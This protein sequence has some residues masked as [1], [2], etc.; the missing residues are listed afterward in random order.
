[1]SEFEISQFMK[2]LSGFMVVSFVL[3]IVI[4]VMQFFIG[5]FTVVIFGYGVG[6]L[7]LMVYNLIGCIKYYKNINVIKNFSTKSE[8]AGCVA[9]F[10]KSIPMC[11]IF[12]F[13]NLFLGGFI[14]FIGN[15]YDLILAYYVKSKKGELLM[16][17]SDPIIHDVY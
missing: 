10:E 8:A 11:W 15:L 13:L 17:V 4:V 14:G 12:M 5:I 1:M 16:P 9:Y 7:I 3:W 2:K 6:T